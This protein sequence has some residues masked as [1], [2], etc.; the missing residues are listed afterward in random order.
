[1]YLPAIPPSVPPKK[2]DTLPFDEQVDVFPDGT[3]VINEDT[4]GLYAV[5]FDATNPAPPAAPFKYS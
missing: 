3:I 4:T 2:N 1:V 5:R